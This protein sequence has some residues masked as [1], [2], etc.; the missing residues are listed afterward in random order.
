[1]STRV[2]GSAL[3]AGLTIAVLVGQI[4]TNRQERREP[5][6]GHPLEPLTLALRTAGE[7][8]FLPGGV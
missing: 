6:L 3:V 4:V 5:D 1:M 7:Q 8:T 2:P